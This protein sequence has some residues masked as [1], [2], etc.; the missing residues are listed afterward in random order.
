MPFSPKKI[1]MLVFPG[2]DVDVPSC[3][4]ELSRE[5]LIRVYEGEGRRYLAI[6]NFAVHQ[7]IE[8]KVGIEPPFSRGIAD[9]PRMI[10]NARRR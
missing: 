3:L 8:K 6:R 5:D 9:I 7:R 2:D 4:E 1:K 10:P